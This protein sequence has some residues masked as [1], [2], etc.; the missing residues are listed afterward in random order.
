MGLSKGLRYGSSVSLSQTFRVVH[1]EVDG[2][3]DSLDN[4]V[5]ASGSWESGNHGIS[6]AVGT[7]REANALKWK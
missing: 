2:N 6:V 4:I 3:R 1:R 5:A 7:I